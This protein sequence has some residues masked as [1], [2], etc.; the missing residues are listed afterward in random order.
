MD[1]LIYWVSFIVSLL[2]VLYVIF[3]FLYHKL[4]LQ[5]GAFISTDAMPT[6]KPVPIPTKNQKSPFHKLAVFIFEV[7]QWELIENWHYKLNP[8]VELVIPKG[9]RFDGASIPRPFWAILS[10]IGLLLIPG[11]LHDYAYKYDQLWQV[12]ADGMLDSFQKGAGKEFWDGLFINVGKDVN[13]IL[14]IN[15]IA[16]LAVFFGGNGTWNKYRDES[17]VAEK[18]NLKG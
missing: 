9:F 16:W 2:L 7:R 11:L 18:P 1:Y 13:G 5:V 3:Y 15:V 12:E 8:E 10:P 4:D 6:L 17:A 14:L